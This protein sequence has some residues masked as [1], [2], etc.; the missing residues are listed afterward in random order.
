[1]KEQYASRSIVCLLISVSLGA[2]SCSDCAVCYVQA[3]GTAW[4]CAGASMLHDTALKDY[5][6]RLFLD[7]HSM[8]VEHWNSQIDCAIKSSKVSEQQSSWNS[9]GH[10][11]FVPPETHAQC[12]FFLCALYMLPLLAVLPH[13]LG[14]HSRCMHR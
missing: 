11:A 3:Q 12:R 4:G 9:S 7:K 13:H 6:L 5:G 10:I 8:R 2:T 1:M 14:R